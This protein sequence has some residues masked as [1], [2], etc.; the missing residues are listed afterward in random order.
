MPRARLAL[1]TEKPSGLLPGA[2]LYA[3]GGKRVCCL[4][5]SCRRQME[6][7]AGVSAAVVLSSR[8]SGECMVPTTFHQGWIHSAQRT[9]H[10]CRCCVLPCTLLCCCLLALV[11]QNLRPLGSCWRDCV[12]AE[13]MVAGRCGGVGERG[14]RVVAAAMMSTWELIWQILSQWLLLLSSKPPTFLYGRCPR[15]RWS[16]MRQSCIRALQASSCKTWIQTA[17]SLHGPPAAAARTRYRQQPAFTVHH[18]PL[19]EPDTDSNQPSQST[20]SRCKSQIQTATSLHSPTTSSCMGTTPHLSPT[21]QRGVPDWTSHSNA[22]PFN[23][24]CQLACGPRRSGEQCLQ[25]TLAVH[26]SRLGRQTSSALLQIP[27]DASEPNQQQHAFMFA[28]S[29]P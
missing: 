24:A 5:P 17:T 19:Q 12:R 27:I 1:R 20:T 4:L 23:T 10:G 16:G 28:C 29:A 14:V 8:V 7:T 26:G 18:Q 25:D 9:Q 15:G 21:G 11:Q 6:A 2:A 22:Q 3:R 13:G